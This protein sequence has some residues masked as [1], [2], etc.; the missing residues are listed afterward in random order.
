[1]IG[2]VLTVFGI[3]LLPLTR[4]RVAATA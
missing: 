1:V 4:F 2:I 3:L